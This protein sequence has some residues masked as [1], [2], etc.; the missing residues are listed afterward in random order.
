LQGIQTS[1]PFFHEA[2]Y[3]SCPSAM[4]STKSR[5]ETHI[6]DTLKLPFVV[7]WQVSM[8]SKSRGEESTHAGA[9]HTGAWACRRAFR[10][11]KKYHTCPDRQGYDMCEVRKTYITLALS[12]PR[13]VV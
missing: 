4:R 13:V 6:T 1:L 9:H 8:K 12:S 7:I 5:A 11:R 2:S 3:L 10:G